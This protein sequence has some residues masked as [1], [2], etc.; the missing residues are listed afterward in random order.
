MP[1]SLFCRVTLKLLRYADSIFSSG[2]EET[3][4]DAGISSGDSCVLFCAGSYPGRSR[5]GGRLIPAQ[6]ATIFH[7]APEKILHSCA[8]RCHEEIRAGW[9]VFSRAGGNIFVFQA[10]LGT[11]SR[12]E[13]S[14]GGFRAEIAVKSCAE[15]CHGGFRAEKAAK[16][17]A[18][19]SKRSFQRGFGTVFPPLFFC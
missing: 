12:A 17:R 10:G 5:R 6:A 18:K 9:T 11:D 16:F 1:A 8:E 14:Y 19:C 7:S 4:T 3:F 15:R 2:V 13:R